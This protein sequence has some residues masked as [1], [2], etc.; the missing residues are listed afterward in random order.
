MP[1]STIISLDV[2]EGGMWASFMVAGGED[3]LAMGKQR[4]GNKSMQ[5]RPK[6]YFLCPKT[7]LVNWK[8]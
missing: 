7:L 3:M 5:M 2:L 8:T 6:C 4:I 1:L